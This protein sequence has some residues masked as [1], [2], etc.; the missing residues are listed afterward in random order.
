MAAT[1]KCP[2]CGK[3]NNKE[4]TETY[5]K[6]YYCPDCLVKKKNENKKNTDGWDD[7]F[8][9]IK[10][11]YGHP[12]TPM[13]F[14]QLSD[15]RKEPY[16]CTNTGMLLTLKYF[17]E[18][19]ENKVIEGTGLGIIPWAYDKAKLDYIKKKKVN[20]TNIKKDFNCNRIKIKVSPSK[21]NK[22]LVPIKLE[23][24]KEV[25]EDADE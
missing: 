21:C 2:V 1:V 15:F 24:I 4:D 20:D 13:M 18:T 10:L 5:K 17:Y 22:K 8:E 9:Y 3:L 16:N 19:M 25:E 14:K 23:N 11:L 12:P 7:L 6:R